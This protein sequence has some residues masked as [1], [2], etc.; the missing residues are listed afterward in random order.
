MKSIR[1][2]KIVFLQVLIA[3]TVLA[4]TP[5]SVFAGIFAF[6]DLQ[7]AVSGTQE[8]KKQQTSFKQEFQKEQMLI[9]EKEKLI[10]KT[11]D[12]LNKQSFVLDPEQKRE[13][14]EKFREEKRDFERYVQ[15]KN[16]EFGRRE[17]EITAKLIEKMI[18]IVRKI[19]K[20]K[21]FESVMDVKTAIYASPESDITDIATKFYDKTHPANSSTGGAGGK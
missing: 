17:K 9:A 21:K 14:Q 13:K 10:K 15:D 18:D 6:V 4:W 8:W 7:K 11:F 3:F 2:S 12:E 5:V 1:F 19:G 20:E 16:D